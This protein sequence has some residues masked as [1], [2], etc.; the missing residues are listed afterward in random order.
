MKN[1]PT[2]EKK[3][4]QYR[5]EYKA[6]GQVVQLCKDIPAMELAVKI[7][8]SIH[9]VCNNAHIMHVMHDDIIDVTFVR[10]DS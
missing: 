9:E 10:Y 6:N 4:P 1:N 7:A 3:E 8:L 2:T 5:I